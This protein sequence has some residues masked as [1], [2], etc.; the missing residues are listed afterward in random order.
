[1][2]Q[3]S[4]HE[5][6]PYTRHT[7]ES[8]SLGH[9]FSV[10]PEAG[11]NV[12][13]IWFDGQSILDGFTTPDELASGKWGKS[14]LLF[15]F[16][17]RLLDGRFEYEGKTYQWPI[18]NADTRNAIHG[19]IRDERFEVVTTQV[20]GTQSSMTLGVDY[21]GHHEFYPFACRLEITFTITNDRQF[22]V[23][24]YVENRSEVALPFGFGWHPYFRLTPSANDH[25]LRLPN[26]PRVEIDDRMIPTGRVADQSGFQQIERIDN[27]FVD[28][29]F[30]VTDAEYEVHLRGGDRHLTVTCD[31]ANWPFF[32]VFTPPHRTSVALEP[33]T[34]NVNALNNG[35]GLRL[36]AAGQSWEASF[37]CQLSVI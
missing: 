7:I 29:C 33:M 25:A 6:G 22:W 9:G 3:I 26:G 12:L 23:S 35:D 16:P 14:T 37:R 15:P 11:A 28:N 4:S 31:R 24:V 1:V 13:D 18:N 36:L 17:N 27:Q 30:R 21:D 8:K 34:C 32:Q 20:S 2:Y 10:V 5:F 19:F